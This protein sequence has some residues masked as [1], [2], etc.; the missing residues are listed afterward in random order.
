[1]L[2]HFLTLKYK[3]N[4]TTCTLISGEMQKVGDDC[5]KGPEF[6]LLGTELKIK[7]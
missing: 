3:C 1:M 4:L 2:I 6:S 7:G 5:C